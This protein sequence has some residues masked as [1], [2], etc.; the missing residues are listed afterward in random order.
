[1]SPS[2]LRR[3]MNSRVMAALADE[4]LR[5]D[6]VRYFAGRLAE[7]QQLILELVT[8]DSKHRLAAVLLHL[9]R[10]LGRRDANLLSMQ[11]RITQ[12][13]LAS[14][15]GTTRS[16]VGYFL[17]QFHHAG[18]VEKSRGVFLVVNEDRL[19]DYLAGEHRPRRL[20]AVGRPPSR[21]V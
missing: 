2:T 13:E 3:I 21:R 10:K 14:M 15:V 17:K 16:R 1:M 19:E 18:F 11:E 6:F 8:G 12:E 7:Q 4:G 9:A 20:Y 5:D